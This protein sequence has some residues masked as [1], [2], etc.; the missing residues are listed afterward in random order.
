[1]AVASPVLPSALAE[2]VAP[3]VDHTFVSD[4]T[5]TEATLHAEINPGG[6]A[7]SYRFQYL[8]EAKFHEEGESFSG[9]A[10]TPV[11]DLQAEDGSPAEDNND[12]SASALLSGLQ[13]DAAY[14][15]RAIA[16]NA[17]GEGEGE[18]FQGVLYSRGFH[19]EALAAA[20]PDTCPNAAVRAELHSGFLPDCRAY[21]RVT[22]ADN[23]GA[24]VILNPQ[25]IRA[26]ADGNAIQFSTLV[27][28][29]DV[30]GTSVSTDYLAVR[31]PALGWQTHGITP[32]QDSISFAEAVFSLEPRY[33][34]E[35]SPDLSRGVFLAAS[36]LTGEGPDVAT[37]ANFYLRDNLLTPGP[38][39]YRLLTDATTP[40]QAFPNGPYRIV[41]PALADATAD[42]HKL[43]FEST[44][45]LTADTV[46][47]GFD[48]ESP[49]L[50]EWVD[51]NPPRLVM[52]GQVPP[53]GASHCGAGGPACQPSISQAGQGALQNHYTDG[54]ISADGSR[55]NFTRGESC[56]FPPDLP[57]GTLFVRD[58]RGTTAPDDDT[59]TQLNLSER[60]TPEPP[61]PARF[62]AA[63]S[64]VDAAG[65]RIPLHVFFTSSEQ[66]TE[67]P[68]AGLYR[69]D[70]QPDSD[71][72]HLTLIGPGASGFFG[73]SAD[74][75]YAYFASPDQLIPGNPSDAVVQRIYVWHQGELHEVG[76]VENGPEF[77]RLA[78]GPRWGS[79][80]LTA[81]VTPDGTHAL[82]VTQGTNEL[83]SLYGKPEYD[84]GSS[85]P[86]YTDL[87]CSE[88]YGYD[89]AANAGAGEL[90][91][92][93]CNPSGAPAT[94][95]AGFDGNK[96]GI[97]GSRDSSHV[98]HALSADGRYVFFTSGD[99]L[100]PEDTNGA[101]DIYEFD[102][103]TSTVHL[104]SSGTDPSGATFL[105][106]SPD[107]HDVFFV[108]RE[109]L[110]PSD[111]DRSRDLYD[112]RIGGGIAQA[113]AAAP[114]D[115]LG[116]GCQPAAAPPS[117][118]AF[119]GTGAELGVSKLGQRR[120]RGGRRAVRRHGATR[121]V[122]RKHRK[123]AGNKRGAGR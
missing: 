68:G 17:A 11:E 103:A 27:G 75:S 73:A 100:V 95:D 119:A 118:P 37:V 65:N 111:T 71:G 2:A 69:W 67:A 83:L 115:P 89:A 49:K 47:A 45:N 105:D 93:S 24:D 33:V 92:A 31:D 15:Y 53:P 39:S 60:A 43:I 113:P 110:V 21:E 70:E 98:N 104:L 57:C 48:T 59:T 63:S 99:R 16:T 84:H 61:L 30:R 9:A 19:T 32:P 46:A 12:H 56:A 85:C 72:H 121:C 120:C 38:G 94:T 80:P 82:F 20:A 29:G 109:P 23:N 52:V 90:Q 76:A 5:A 22:P 41:Q 8:T 81:R 4:V 34:G 101:N 3:S 79:D 10:Q 55:I 78:G 64:G 88:I 123:P 112:A 122:K 35:L 77:D 7:T 74:G 51:G 14:R 62:W 28:M 13:P 40:Q 66:L 6:T 1:M 26:G 18:L 91:C 102:A 107:G 114:C 96:V 116:G 54:T 117:P 42:F 106:A 108:T 86:N 36:P 87:K 50:Y 58:D 97:G 25:R 44:R